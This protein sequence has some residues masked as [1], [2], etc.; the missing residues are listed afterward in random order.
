MSWVQVSESRWERQANGMESYFIAI[1]NL[2]AS[3]CEGRRQYT[4]NSRLKLRY[5]QPQIAATVEGIKKVYEVPDDS[6]L[7]NWLERTFITSDASDAEALSREVTPIQQ[8]TLYYLPRSSELLIRAPHS[9]IDGVGMIMLWHSYLTAI[10]APRE[11][12]FG[13]EATRL[14]NTLETLLHHPDPPRA[15]MTAKAQEIIDAFVAAPGLGPMNNVGKVPPGPTQ[16]RELAFSVETT[17]SIVC[18]CKDNGYSVSAAVH[19]A[20]IQT[21]IKHAHPAGDKTKYVTATNPDIRTF[22]PKP[23]NTSNYA[24][25]LFYTPWAFQIDPPPDSFD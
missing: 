2:T 21:L 22:L 24:A 14:P 9:L 3:L 12:A 6:A 4:I 19:A 18:A 20:F 11:I 13:D 1:E 17:S 15:E 5:E 7:E 8:A 23:Y 25:A 16:R 10:T